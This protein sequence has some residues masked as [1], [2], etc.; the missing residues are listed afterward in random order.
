MAVGWEELLLVLIIILLLFGPQRLPKLARSIGEAVK[1][2]KE[3][4]KD[5]PDKPAKKKK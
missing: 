1:E 2:F 4:M 5:K 3:G